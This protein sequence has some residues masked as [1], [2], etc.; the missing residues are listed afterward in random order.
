MILLPHSIKLIITEKFQNEK[1]EFYFTNM[2]NQI[3]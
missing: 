1:F 2:R 3:F